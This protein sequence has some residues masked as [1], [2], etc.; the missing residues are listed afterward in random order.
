VLTIADQINFAEE[1]TYLGKKRYKEENEGKRK[2][3]QR[4]LVAF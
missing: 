4:A 3:M 1:K 2:H